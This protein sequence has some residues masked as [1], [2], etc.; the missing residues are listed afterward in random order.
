MLSLE[1]MFPQS[2][3]MIC[4]V[5]RMIRWL[6]CCGWSP[7]VDNDWAGSDV[8]TIS[9]R[10]L[11]SSVFWMVWWRAC[12]VFVMV[13]SRW[14]GLCVWISPW[15]W[16][17]DTILVWWWSSMIALRWW[18]S[19]GC[20]LHLAGSPVWME[21]MEGH[22][23]VV[24]WLLE[25]VYDCFGMM[26]HWFGDCGGAMLWWCSMTSGMTWWYQEWADACLEDSDG[27]PDEDGIWMS[28]EMSSPFQ[29]GCCWSYDYGMVWCAHIVFVVAR[30]MM[31]LCGVMLTW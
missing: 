17:G 30:Q 14:Y 13:V 24:W 21:K 29:A 8:T 31:W 4:I 15:S 12:V 7:A 20:Q 25:E 18:L 11:W 22:L 19:A 16:S 10:M 26:G 5:Q 6:P 1:S 2:R 28:M 27:P 23:D 3:L 9:S